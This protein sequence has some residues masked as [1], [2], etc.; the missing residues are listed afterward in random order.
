MSDKSPRQTAS[1]RSDKSI[2]QKRAIKKSRKAVA[3]NDRI[4]AFLRGGPPTDRS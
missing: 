3:E 2:K 4:A 1:R